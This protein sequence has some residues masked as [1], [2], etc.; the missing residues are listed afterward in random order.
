MRPLVLSLA[1]AATVAAG[2]GVLVTAPTASQDDAQPGAAASATLEPSAAAPSRTTDADAGLLAGGTTPGLGVPTSGPPVAPTFP[3]APTAE[4]PASVTATGQPLLASAAASPPAPTV[5]GAFVVVLRDDADVSAVRAAL[6]TEP[7]RVYTTALRGFAVRLDAASLERVRNHPGVAFVEPDQVV[8]T[9][10]VQG[11]PAG[12]YGLDRLDQRRLPLNGRYAYTRT[13]R[14]VTAYVI[15]T[16][17]APHRDFGTRAANVFDAFGGRGTD[18]NGHGTHVAGTVGSATFGV[19]KEVALRG[20]RVL[21]CEGSGS[22]SSVLAGVD[23]VAA[24]RRLPAVA[25][26]SLGGLLS[27][28]LDGAV[29][30]L[31][32]RGVAVAVAAG[33][34]S[35]DACL[36]SPA[37][38]R[39]VLT[40]AASDRN[41]LHAFFSNH[42]ACVELYAPGVDIRSTS[43]R[44]GTEV[45]SGTSMATPHVAGV[46]ALQLQ[47][48]TTNAAT[49]VSRTLSGATAGTVRLAPLTTP[50]RL[51]HKGNL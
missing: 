13:G 32:D 1:V 27:P 9:A 30:R 41:D 36:V 21:D 15:D 18:C 6:G 28:A 42:G 49:A 39:G 25:T 38:A 50:N 31:V 22:T 10:A 20:V 5:P 4:A 8:R 47:G 17:I 46:L 24:T 45:L 3:T 43:L 48:G 7:D 29:S 51:L 19:A 34:E 26:L 35:I 14:G 40:V 23:H 44:G 12:L 37:R 2:T 11:T 16:G 33:N